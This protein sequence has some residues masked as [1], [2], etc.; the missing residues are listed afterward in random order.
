MVFIS[1]VH[2]SGKTF[3]CEMAKHETGLETFSASKLIEQYKHSEF[4]KDKL[5][6]DID[7]N[8]HCLLSAANMLKAS[9]QNFLLD[10]H[11]CL[12]DALGNV[13][14]IPQTIFQTLNPEAIVLLMEKPEIIATRRIERDGVE[15]SLQTIEYFQQEEYSY[16]KEISSLINAKLFISNGSNMLQYL[17]S[18]P[19]LF[20]CW[21]SMDLSMPGQT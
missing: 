9:G 14:R 15:V 13:T 5:I 2:G 3:F 4:E 1:G 21:K 6:P 16:A 11:L 10:G 20:R 7:D 19:I 12:L 17:R 8:Q 18:T